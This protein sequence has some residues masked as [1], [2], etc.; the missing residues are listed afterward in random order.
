MMMATLLGIAL[1]AVAGAGLATT[2]D[3][4]IDVDFLEKL[5]VPGRVIEPSLDAEREQAL[6]RAL[7]SARE[8]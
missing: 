6:Q 8:D 4:G 1:G 2:V 5:G 3:Q 7:D